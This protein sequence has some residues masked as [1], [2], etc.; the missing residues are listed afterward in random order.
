MARSL[1]PWLDR[2]AGRLADWTAIAALFGGGSTAL[3]WL[4]STWDLISNQGIAAI[5]FTG[6]AAMSLL[7]LSASALMVAWRKIWPLPAALL[8]VTSPAKRQDPSQS[9][10]EAIA[11][12]KEWVYVWLNDARNVSGTFAIACNVLFPRGGQDRILAI[13]LQLVSV[14]GNDEFGILKQYFERGDTLQEIEKAISR[15]VN[16]IHKF[17]FDLA[18]HVVKLV[19]AE[20]AGKQYEMGLDRDFRCV[21]RLREI[22]AR[23]SFGDIMHTF[24]SMSL[25]PAKERKIAPPTYMY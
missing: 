25:M 9:E 5:I 8:P 10:L 17:Q 7:A 14:K 4:A 6:L 15:Y 16:G 13:G 24:V 3:S 12:L 22:V 19:N 1:P 18:P 21:M 11:A 23:H 20:E 2:W